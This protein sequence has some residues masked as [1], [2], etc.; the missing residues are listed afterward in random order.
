MRS[1]VAGIICIP[2][3]DDPSKCTMKC[4][5]EADLQGNVPQ[6]VFAVAIKQVAWGMVDLRRLIPKFIKN[7]KEVA[8]REPVN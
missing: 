7:N 2:E 6:W 3:K 1:P 5:I 8:A 4:I